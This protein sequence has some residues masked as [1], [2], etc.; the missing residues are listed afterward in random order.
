MESD[1]TVPNKILNNHVY[2]IIRK[3]HDYLFRF[4]P[5][6][7]NEE[8][9]IPLIGPNVRNF[10]YQ[11]AS[12]M[13]KKDKEFIIRKAA[14]LS[15]YGALQLFNQDVLNTVTWRHG[16]KSVTSIKDQQEEGLRNGSLR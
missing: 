3:A 5:L 7:E 4:Q 16:N 13:H 8:W 14:S 10:V 11:Q 12:K 1:V 15:I 9:K 6:T 2:N